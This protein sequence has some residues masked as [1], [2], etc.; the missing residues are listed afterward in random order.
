MRKVI[1]YLL[2]LLVIS[3]CSDEERNSILESRGMNGVLGTSADFIRLSDDSTKLAGVLR[4]NASTS[5]I[6]LKWNVPEGCNIDTTLT[7]ME[8]SNGT[9]E[10]SIQ[11]AKHL[12]D[13]VYGPKKMAFHGGV[14]ISAGEYSKYVNLIWADEVDSTAIASQPVIRTRAEEMPLPLVDVI[15][16]TEDVIELE[17]GN[18]SQKS[19]SI[20]YN[21]SFFPLLSLSKND[22]WRGDLIE[23]DIPTAISST[24][25]TFNVGW[26]TGATP[27]NRSFISTLKL[28]LSGI[29]KYFYVVY[30]YKDPELPIFRYDS[31]VPD[32]TVLLPAVGAVVAVK[33]TTNQEWT[34]TST[35]SIKS[36]ITGD[37]STL[38]LKTLAIPIDDNP[39]E[40]ERDV[41]VTVASSLGG[42]PIVLKF[43][44]QARGTT[45]SVINIDPVPGTDIPAIGTNVNVTVLTSSGWWIDCLGQRTNYA[46]SQL[47]GR[48]TIPANPETVDRDITISIGYGSTID[49]T[50]VYK[51][52]AG[53]NLQFVSITPGGRI[54]VTGGNYTLNFEGDFAGGVMVEAY[55]DGVSGALAVSNT[56][57]NK[58]PQIQIPANYDNLLSRE[59]KF[60]YKKE[61]SGDW[62]DITAV[63]TQDGVTITPNGIIPQDSLP[64]TGGPYS[65]TFSGLYTGTIYLRA[66]SGSD[67]IVRSSGSIGSIITLNIPENPKTT[68]RLL[69]FSYSGDGVNWIDIN[70]TRIQQVNAAIGGGNTTVNEFENEETVNGD[71]EL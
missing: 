52:L 34:L 30:I 50:F 20:I 68:Q 12:S 61:N 32:T 22:D 1:Y 17:E 51:Q 14:L 42:N 66:V 26:K 16:L 10:L 39:F 13:S 43:R 67:E 41:R 44:Q 56:A 40:V 62:I 36:P 5:E 47:S 59:I 63:K 11:W 24:P 33:A 28:S 54:P 65:C 71:L 25:Y 8:L 21:D 37:A 35:E 3:A 55:I 27:P 53:T 48:V 9:G 18:Y 19:V 64:A 7:K 31:C 46:E 60:R 38:G 6:D 23:D 69:T 29:I 45:F 49:S 58:K 4:I 2:A 57:Y 15:I 70:E